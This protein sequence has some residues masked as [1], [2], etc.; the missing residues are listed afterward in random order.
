MYELI[1]LQS[2]QAQADKKIYC[3]IKMFFALLIYL[4]FVNV[5]IDVD[6]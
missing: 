5:N 4:F 2:W 6:F 1:C 3:N